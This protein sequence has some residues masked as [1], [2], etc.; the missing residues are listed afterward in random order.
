MNVHINET[1]THDSLRYIAYFR[2]IR[3]TQ[4]WP[5]VYYTAIC[6]QNVSNRIGPSRRI[7]DAA[8][9]Q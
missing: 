7:D 8:A 9:A 4:A 3:R 6:E 5:H 2:I 1:G